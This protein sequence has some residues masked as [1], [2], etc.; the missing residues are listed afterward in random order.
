[1]NNQNSLELGNDVNFPNL[2]RT[3]SDTWEHMEAILTDNYSGDTAR[4]GR[5]LNNEG[6]V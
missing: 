6:M 1:M 4:Y 5:G 2:N 3:A